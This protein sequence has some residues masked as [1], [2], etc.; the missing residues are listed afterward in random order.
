MNVVK[1]FLQNYYL[2]HFIRFTQAHLKK[3]AEVIITVATQAQQN[4]GGKIPRK[5]EDVSTK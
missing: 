3:W 5:A 1:L 4:S 2:L